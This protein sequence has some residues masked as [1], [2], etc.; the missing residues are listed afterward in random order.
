MAYRIYGVSSVLGVGGAESSSS[1]IGLS[2]ARAS[3]ERIRSSSNRISI[4][5][6]IACEFMSVVTWIG[7][8]AA[9]GWEFARLRLGSEGGVDLR[10]T[11]SAVVTLSWSAA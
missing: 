7:F 4:G 6:P 2:E 3:L 9:P 10:T 5:V 8:S 1:N 11:V